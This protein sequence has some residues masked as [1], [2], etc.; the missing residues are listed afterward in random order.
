MRIE[1]LFLTLRQRMTCLMSTI[2]TFV[3][4]KEMIK[5]AYSEKRSNVISSQR[6]LIIEEVDKLL[7]VLINE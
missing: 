5:A 2:S 6:P 3:K 1:F 4:N 7:L